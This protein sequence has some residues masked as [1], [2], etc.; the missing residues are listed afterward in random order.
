MVRVVQLGVTDGARYMSSNSG[1]S[2]LNAAFSFNQ[3][4]IMGSAHYSF[5]QL[6]CCSCE[7]LSD[8]S[9]AG[10]SVGISQV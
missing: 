10:N 1:G 7:H 3:K 9:A 2:W 6:G 4:V 8:T 5:C